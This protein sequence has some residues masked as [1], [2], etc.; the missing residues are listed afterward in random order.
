LTG[1]LKLPDHRNFK[2]LTVVTV[3]A[4][5]IG[6]SL[7]LYANSN[8]SLVFERLYVW[9]KPIEL[10]WMLLIRLVVI[11]LMFL[12]IIVAVA[13]RS[14]DGSTTKALKSAAKIHL[15]LLSITLIFTLISVAVLLRLFVITPEIAAAFI[16]TADVAAIVHPFEIAQVTLDS[17]NT[18]FVWP[19]LNAVYGQILVII[20][21]GFL[22][23]VG[24]LRLPDSMRLPILAV[25]AKAANVCMMVISFMLY[26]MPLGV[27]ALSYTVAMSKGSS[28][29]MAVLFFII[30]VSGLM[31]C[32]TL[33]LYPATAWF[34]KIPNRLFARAIFPAQTV[35]FGTRSSLM[36]LGSLT[37]G[38]ERVIGIPSRITSVVLPVSVSTFKLNRMV[39]TPAKLFFLAHLYSIELAVVTSA[40]LLALAFIKSFGT[41]GIPSGGTMTT[42]PLYLA[43]GIPLEGILILK[44]VDVIPDIFKTILNVTEDLAV[45]TIAA[46]MAGENF[47]VQTLEALPVS[48]SGIMDHSAVPN[49][50]P[51][52]ADSVQ[53]Q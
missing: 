29:L 39:S 8:P 40:T 31:I 17:W 14:K 36:C 12:Y 6:F 26:L 5:V 34:G 7:G 43:A 21:A 22:I 32:V 23:A 18:L 35:A 28:V 45:T 10:S 24:L 50:K 2:W 52:S 46:R 33:L 13:G 20:A 53:L 47:E 9:S 25:F 38:A 15:L 49:M 42:L 48:S 44:A 16:A 19:V 11:P 37:T 3:I 51:I 4:L 27:L 41:A 1:Q 30:L